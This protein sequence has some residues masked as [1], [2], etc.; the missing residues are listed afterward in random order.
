MFSR[1]PRI[2][3]PRLAGKSLRP[4]EDIA[5]ST[6]AEKKEE[7]IDDSPRV[8]LKIHQR[9]LLPKK[10][11]PL[12]PLTVLESLKRILSDHTGRLDVRCLRTIKNRIDDFQHSLASLSAFSSLSRESGGMKEH[13]MVC[14]TTSYSSPA[15]RNEKDLLIFQFNIDREFV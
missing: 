7:S 13:A 10:P 12:T 3:R 11:Q 2:N 14:C 1:G 5:T 4:L 8:L 15:K 6:N 9:N